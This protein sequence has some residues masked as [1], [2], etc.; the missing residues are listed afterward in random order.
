MAGSDTLIAM[1]VTTWPSTATRVGYLLLFGAGSTVAMA[2]HS[3]LLG[4]PL[5]RFGSNRTFVRTVTL[6]VGAIS[7]A[8]GLVCSYPLVKQWFATAL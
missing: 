1:L 3:S 7:T 6:I 2:A 4:W 5:A 8:L